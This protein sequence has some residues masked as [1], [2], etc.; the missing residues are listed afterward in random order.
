MKKLNYGKAFMIQKEKYNGTEN[1]NIVKERKKE[2][3]LLPTDL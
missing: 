1:R 3:L 2:K